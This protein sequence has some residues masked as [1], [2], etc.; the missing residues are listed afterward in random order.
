MQTTEGIDAAVA[1][2]AAVDWPDGAGVDIH[3]GCDDVTVRV[4]VSA[5]CLSDPQAPATNVIPTTTSMLTARM[6]RCGF[7]NSSMANILSMR[8]VSAPKSLRPAP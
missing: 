1:A 8:T 2:G 3:V 5:A 6:T 7:P 4:T